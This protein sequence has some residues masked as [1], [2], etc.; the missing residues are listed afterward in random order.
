VW[1]AGFGEARIGRVWPVW[2]WLGKDSRVF[3]C[4][5][6]NWKYFTKGATMKKFLFI[7][8]IMLLLTS[9]GVSF[10]Q[11]ST[12][13]LARYGQPESRTLEEKNKYVPDADISSLSWGY[14]NP[15]IVV[16]FSRTG[17]TW[18]SKITKY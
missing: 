15:R 18:E 12:P 17:N 16:F 10:E 11:V 5:P 14:L 1:Q 4:T 7:V 6:K 3:Q 8:F 9:C 13:I 2:A